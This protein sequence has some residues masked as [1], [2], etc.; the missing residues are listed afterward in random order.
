MPAAS[1]DAIQPRR[2][3]PI[4]MYHQVAPAPLKASPFTPLVVPPERFAQHMHLLCTL[5]LRGLSMRQLEPYLAGQ[6]SGRVVGITFDDGYVGCLEH[7]APVLRT[8]GF[9]ATCYMVS[10]H[11]GGT[12]A[13]DEALGL[14]SQPLMDASQLRAWVDAG[15]DLGAHTRQHVRLLRVD[16]AIARDEIVGCRQ[17]LEKRTQCEVRHFAYPYGEYA[18]QHLAMVR[19]AGFLTATTN[20]AQRVTG[21]HGALELPRFAVFSDTTLTQL[22]LRVG[23]G[24]ER[25]RELRRAMQRLTAPWRAGRPA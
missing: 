6:L 23:F 21:T 25:L 5:G 14:P 20:V 13:W 15:H 3:I 19:E 1:A 18:P 9:S 4:L 11:V 10:G 24:A 17:E 22:A 12:N 7:A 8:Y 16:E 2:P